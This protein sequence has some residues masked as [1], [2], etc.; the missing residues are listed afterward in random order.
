MLY[1]KRIQLLVLP[2][3]DGLTGILVG[4]GIEQFPAIKGNIELHYQ[5]AIDCV[6]GLAERM[7][8]ARREE[9]ILGAADLA[10]YFH[11]PFGPGWALV[12]DAGYHKDPTNALGISDAFRDAELLAEAIDT[13]FSG[14]APLDRALAEYERRRNEAALPLYQTNCENALFKRPS[15]ELLEIRAALKGANQDDIDKF[16][17][18]LRGRIPREE[19]FNDAN[20]RRIRAEAE[21]RI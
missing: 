14:T 19:F 6:P 17:W 15:P 16:Y 11:K 10:N 9:R 1:D 18:A 20:L 8:N 13:G 2:T 12:G 5:K 4:W 3:N 7:Q 21:Q